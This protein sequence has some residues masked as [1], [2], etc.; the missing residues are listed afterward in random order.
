MQQC[1]VI[2][3]P[4]SIY[5]PNTP[6][7]KVLVNICVIYTYNTPCAFNVVHTAFFL[8]SHFQECRYNKWNNLHDVTVNNTT[9]SS[10]FRRRPFFFVVFYFRFFLL[11]LSPSLPLGFF[12]DTE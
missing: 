9:L 6:T 4:Y 10:V 7:K 2:C 8:Q 1:S 3:Y 5:S 12:G 11:F